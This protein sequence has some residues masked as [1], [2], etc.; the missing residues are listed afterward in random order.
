MGNQLAALTRAA[1]C[2]ALCAGGL[3]AQSN[4]D[5]TVQRTLREFDVPGI[6]VGV[7]QDGKV[8]VAKGYGVRK[9]GDPAAVTPRTLFGIASNTK[10]FTSAALAILVDEKKISW[11]QRVVDI[12]PSFQMSDP[13][14]TREMRVRDL[15]VHRSGLGL[16]AGDLMLFPESD[17]SAA[18]LLRRLRY[19]PLAT[20]FRSKY[21]YDNILYVA[22]GAVIEQAS[23]KSWGAFLKERIF[24]PLGMRRTYAHVTDVSAGED[25]A[26]PHAPDNGKLK[27]VAHTRLD[28]AAPAGAIQS[29]VE[30]MLKWVAAQ[31]AEGQYA[32]GRLFSAEQ[33]REMWTPHIFVP[34]SAAAPPELAALKPNFQTYALG[35]GVSDYRGRKVVSHTGGL[36]GMVTRVT[37][38][39]DLKLGVVVFTNQENGAAF[40]AVTMTILDHYLG[41]PATDWVTAYSTVRKRQLSDARAGV[42]KAAAARAADSRTSLALAKYAGRYRDP[43]YGDVVVEERNG[44]LWMRFSH[45][46]QLAGPMEHF[47]YDT[48]IV[49]W[50]DRTL[51]ADAYVTFSLSADGSIERVKMK[52][53]SPT[54]DFSYDFHDLA[55]TP[56]PKD[57]PAY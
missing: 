29:S 54:T 18:D 4:L 24:E 32:G 15:L 55:L 34:I 50:A 52:A 38:I 1:A 8:I 25:L 31:L 2:I 14:V 35:W 26:F 41:A 30:D 45:S 39:P 33:S 48:F 9:L 17:L 19:V 20:S 23:G 47:Q 49:R 42:A 40:Q 28:P 27:V 36:N 46:P 12:V 37:M 7:I 43:W 13:Y 11:D 3:L 10:A 53:I 21:A 6:A 16:G 51:D 56:A 5:E 44:G 57:A 22:A